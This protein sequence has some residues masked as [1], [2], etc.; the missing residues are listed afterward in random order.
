[1]FVSKALGVNEENHLTIGGM[2]CVEL[3][4]EYGT[5]LYVF[6]ENEIRGN[7]RIY[8][9]NLKK[10][11]GDNGLILY[12][13]KAFCCKKM[14]KI[15]KEEG[16]GI[17]VV[18][19]GEL[20]TAVSS[21]FPTE[22]IY[23]HGNNK[24]KDEL[25]L[26]LNSG[27]GRIV[28]D[29]S[30]ELNMLNDL[31]GEMGKKADIL[32]RIKPGVDAH[33]HDFIK[34]GQIDSKFGV[35]LENGEATEIIEE[36]TKLSNV[37][38]VGFHCHIGSQIFD[39]EP[40]LSTAEVM[41]GFIKEVKEKFGITISE[42]NLGGGFGVRYVESDDPI[43]YDKYMEAVSR[44]IHELSKKH[45]LPLPKIL[46]E[47]GRSIVA[48]AGITLYT[49]G[50]IK[51]I[52]DVRTY[53]SVDGGMGDNPRYILYN[54]EYD[55]EIANK[56]GDKKSETVTV[57]GKC[58]ESGDLLGENVPLQKAQPGDIL[59]V[60]TTGAYNY[61]MASNYNRIP[62]PAAIFVK[63]GTSKV[64]IKRETYADIMKNDA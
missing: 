35:A 39:L 63:D 4:K 29:N 7:M 36:A 28:V 26:A 55:F 64:V 54:A 42:L 46:M 31:A 44:K 17:D 37:N 58:C 2:D 60:L 23:F 38:L 16:L 13:S 49:V 48:S 10:H 51:E 45:N 24:T 9:D 20:Y 27:V 5:P 11:Y 57:A 61:S 25:I 22:K 53:L 34:T 15:A 50:N 32:F 40:F 21:G 8:A 14:Y 30:F 19:G 12:A 1:M 33:T 3:A 18:S 43:S 62:K 59:A 56:A 47:P 52:K 6:D 41:M